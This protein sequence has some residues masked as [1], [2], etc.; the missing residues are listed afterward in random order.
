[1]RKFRAE[2]VWLCLLALM[3][4]AQGLCII[5]TY[6]TW[7]LFYEFEQFARPCV[8]FDESGLAIGDTPYARQMLRIC[9]IH[10]NRVFI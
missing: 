7:Q 3:H 5:V 6:K 10:T 4:N 2:T 8:E 1:M 9:I